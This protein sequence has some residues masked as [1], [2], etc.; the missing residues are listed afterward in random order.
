MKRGETVLPRGVPQLR[1]R[2]EA[3]VTGHDRLLERLPG[4]YLKHKAHC[5][6]STYSRSVSTTILAEIMNKED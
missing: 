6:Y 1:T 5:P 3:R 2:A 4:C